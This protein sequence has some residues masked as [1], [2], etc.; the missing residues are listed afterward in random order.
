[1]ELTVQLMPPAYPFT[2]VTLPPHYSPPYQVTCN[3]GEP[4]V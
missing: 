2:P 1:M 3:T 4:N